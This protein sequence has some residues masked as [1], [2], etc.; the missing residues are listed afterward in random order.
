[1]RQEALKRADSLI[2]RYDGNQSAATSGETKSTG[3]RDSTF[4]WD[5]TKL[6]DGVYRV[7]VVASDRPSSPSNPQTDEAISEPITIAN[8]LPAAFLFRRAGRESEG[9]GARIDGLATGRATLVGA[10][11]RV[12]G[13]DWTAC[14]AADGIW[15]GAFEP[16]TCPAG[17]LS[18][19]EHTVEV[20]V[21]DAAGNQ[22]TKAVAVRVSQG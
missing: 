1:M 17:P 5:T 2:A 20:R 21:M 12:D 15:D 3:V 4:S 19:G 6:P 10:Q 9:S 14:E 11:F 18:S 7:R 22:F 16:F 13:G 8:G